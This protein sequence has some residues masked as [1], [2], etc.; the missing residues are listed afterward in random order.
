[1]E[2]IAYVGL[3]V[4]KEEAGSTYGLHHPCFKV[5]EAALPIGAAFHASFAL[6]SLKELSTPG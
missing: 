2:R 6:A 4:D 3:D 5:D 1:M